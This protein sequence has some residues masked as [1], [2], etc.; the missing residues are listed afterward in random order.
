MPPIHCLYFLGDL[1][2]LQSDCLT[3]ITSFLCHK[4]QRVPVTYSVLSGSFGGQ[5]GL[6]TIWSL[7]TPQQDALHTC[8]IFHF[9]FSSLYS[10]TSSYHSLITSGFRSVL[11]SHLP[12]KTFLLLSISVILGEPLKL[13]LVTHI[14]WDDFF[15]ILRVGSRPF[16]SVS[17]TLMVSCTHHYSINSCNH[18]MMCLFPPFLRL[19]FLICKT[20]MM[21]IVPI[22]EDCLEDLNKIIYA[23]NL[24]QQLGIENVFLIAIIIYNI[25]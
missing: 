22:S 21:I 19:H 6:F 18:M 25:L 9:H 17:N 23:M 4:L 24:K 20:G 12:D 13:S 16:H 1:P 5:A 15:G 2:I 10:G 8:P 3:E 7:C 11:M 14:L